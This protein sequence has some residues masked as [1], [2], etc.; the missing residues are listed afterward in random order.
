M[1]LY[2]IDNEI[3]SCVDADTGEILDVEK[4]EHLQME[5]D[6]KL[7]GVACWYKDLVADA[8]K[9]RDEEKNLAE[10]RKVLENKAEGLKRY[11][12]DALQGQKFQTSKCV[13]SFRNTSSVELTEPALAIAWAQTHGH[14]EIVTYAAPTISKTELK[15]LLKTEEIPGA[16]LVYSI[17]CGVK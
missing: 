3:L 14:G 6:A 4:L 5:R 13:V 8:A 2:Q 7:E 15:K 16:E 9:I 12:S 10:R 1:N 17:S 11:L